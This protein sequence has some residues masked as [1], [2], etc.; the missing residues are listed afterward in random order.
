MGILSL[1][2]E[3]QQ[4]VNWVLNWMG[5]MARRYGGT[6]HDKSGKTW[7]WGQAL[8]R[9]CYGENWNNIV[10]ETPSWED[11]DRARRWEKGELPDWFMNT[12]TTAPVGGKG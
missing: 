9:E 12:E 10:P 5:R 4:R 11:I 6:V 8:C 2:L 7:D 3:E 1:P